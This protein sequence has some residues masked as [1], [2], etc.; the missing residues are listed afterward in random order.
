MDDE[1]RVGINYWPA[2]TAMRWWRDFDRAEVDRDFATIGAAKCDSVRIFL[3]W[4][5][6]QP[7]ADQV[8]PVALSRLVQVADAA[9]ARGLRLVPTLFT[10]HM[11]GANWIPEWALGRAGTG[12]FPIVSGDAVVERVPR[13]WYDDRA[14]VDAQA[15]FAREVAAALRGHPALWAWDLGNEN[16][17]VCVPA[18]R[19]L[20]RSW[21]ARMTSAIR[22][23]DA[24][25]PITIGL[26]MEDLEEDRRLGPAEAAEVSDFLC[27]HGYPL[28]AKW[29]RGTAD[30]SLPAYLAEVTRWL[31]RK[32][33]LF[34]EF[35]MPSR[36]ATEEGAADGYVAEALEALH[37][38]GTTGAML[39][40]FADY[41][42]EIWDRPPLDRAPHERFFGLWRA[43]GTP[44]PAV[45]HLGRYVGVERRP[46]RP[47][48]GWIDIPRERF[49]EDPGA[50][51]R[52][53]YGR[54]VGEAVTPRT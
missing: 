46:T 32:D 21:L 49:Y 42:P 25:S 3:L 7:A 20:A 28:Y 22:A 12:R 30:A 4:A 17:N 54:Y 11:S 16:S 10:G 41:S 29:A 47:E 18:S 38:V 34:E 43:D 39:W 50:N 13:D 36:T 23:S 24:S 48:G 14:I 53:L 33:V 45:R 1:Y 37:D 27:M 51:L 5:D 15:L 31:G 9:A 8:S 19:D 40:C 44:K 26:H 52:R 6:F 35:G 2:R